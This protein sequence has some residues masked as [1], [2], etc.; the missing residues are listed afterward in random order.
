MALRI[1][2]LTVL[3]ATAAFPQAARTATLVGTV[4]DP[5]GA[6][7][8]GAPVTLTNVETGFL[9]KGVTN[10]E[11]SYYIPFIAVGTYELRVE[12]AGFKAY[13]QKGIELRAA[14]V[15]RIDVR[16]EVGVTSESVQVTGSVP[17]LAT[18]T[19]Q[20]SQTMESRAILQIP[21]H[22]M[23][24]QR[25][26]Y[27]VSGLQMRGADASVVG[28][29]ASA[30]GFTLD[31]VSGKTSIR[32]AIGD[33]NTSVQPA[34][35]ALSEAKVYTTGAPAEMGHASGGILAMTFKSGTNELHG[36]LED[37]WTNNKLTHRGYLQQG[38]LSNPM[39]YHQ[40]LASISGPVVL[41]KLYNGR[42]RTF[43]LFAFGRHHEK[44]DEPQPG[45]VP[46]LNMLGG[47]F[48]FPEAK[49]GGYPIYDPKSIRQVGSTWTADPFSGMQVPKTRF[50]PAVVS[51]LATNPWKAPNS[52]EAATYAR[53]GPTNNY[54]GMT[55]YRSYRSR[56]DSKLD[57]QISPK[58]QFFIRNSWNR[59]RQP[60]ARFGAY[61]NNL[62]LSSVAPGRPNPIDQQS[63]AFADY[64]TF[65]PSL[66]NEVRLGFG[67]RNSTI[68][69]PTAGEG[70]AQKLGIPNV[71]PE[72][73]PMFLSGS[74][75]FYG[76]GPGGFQRNV[77]E[78]VTFQ[79]N[80][81]KLMSRHTIKF[82][83]EL[84]RTRENNVDQALP[85]G[86]YS[87]QTAGTALPFTPNTG[88]IFAS[89]VLGA[90]TSATYTQQ[91]WNRLPRWWSHAGFIQTDWKVRRNLTLNLGL[92][93][94]LET[95]FQDKWGHQ[96]LFDPSLADPLTGRIGAITHPSGGAYKIDRNN[97]Q[98]RVGLAW[99]FRSGMVFRG[100]WGILTQDVMPSAGFQEYQA[101]AVVEQV[102]GDPRPAFYLSQGPPNRNFI[103]NPN[104]TSVFLGTNYSSRGATFIDSNMRLP[105]VMNWSGGIQMQMG[106]TWLTELLYQ[107]SSGVRLTSN[108]NIN[109]LANS[110]YTSTD[111]T[112]LNAVYAAAQNY[113][114]YPQ[115]GTISYFTNGGHNSYH[116]FTARAEKRYAPDGLTLNAHYTW[117]K[118][119]S[120]TV[121]DGWQY[122]N[123]GLTKALT[124]FDTRHRFIFQVMYDVPIGKGRRFRS[125]GG[126][127]NHVIGGWNLIV[128]AS[129]QSGPP[130]TFSFAGSPY[131]YLTGGPSRPNQLAPNDQVEVANWSMGEH[132]FPQSAQKPYYN[133]S[134]F[135]Y[136]AAFTPGSLGASTQT[137]RWTVARQWSISKSWGV[138]RYRFTLRLD[139]NDIPVAFVDTTPNTAVNL[140]SPESFGK[141]A[142]QTGMSFSTM[143]QANGQLILSG[144]FEF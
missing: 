14:E 105:Y 30:I 57:H 138:E 120:G 38:A 131:R 67:R 130:V 144:R 9:Y 87:F 49:G 6:L 139:G 112:L 18:E 126:W 42:N 129:P 76:I 124:S 8:P 2:L 142:L 16:L 20:V 33:T 110:Y 68:S 113:K 45:T 77:N 1:L 135:A 31:G 102:P 83:Y 58:N 85:S 24:V 121:G 21:V 60:V 10:A 56:F 114:P 107:G 108:A 13:V 66:M 80:V 36:S 35:D 133:I 29:P 23:K 94:S 5:T 46:D 17:L 73:F 137:G 64:H 93:Y 7:V 90:V 78:D 95:P 61:L 115:F 101:T 44:G 88:N 62:S 34:L 25:I 32:D 118:N 97:F 119:L 128:N 40:G 39:T 69:P 47:D 70:W 125:S 12:A 140:S 28:Q 65:S 71:G 22:Q 81:T 104:G 103:I 117:S 106:P 134:A 63:W 3:F 26:L 43:F 82:G 55:K 11:G 132:R 122:Y 27:Y 127:L 52:P 37:R 100:S 143:N 50:D 86:S 48:S 15:P 4:T 41:P 141:F 54:L 79:N 98:P 74:S 123:W 84:I 51:F 59:H 89:F 136:P 75:T 111:L 19:S 109:Q 99:N 72:N 116:G 53:T 91:M 96:S 92:R